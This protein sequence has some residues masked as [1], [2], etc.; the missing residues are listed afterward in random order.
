PQKK[1]VLVKYLG[2]N[3]INHFQGQIHF[4]SSDFS[5]EILNTSRQDGQ[6]YEYSVSRGPE[7][8]VQLIQLKVYEPVSRP[9]IQILSRE[10]ANGSCSVALNCTA[11][12]GDDV[13]YS[14]G[15]QDSGAS[16]PCSANSSFLQ[17]SYAPGNASTACVCTASNPVS[18]RAAAF[19]PSG[20][21]HE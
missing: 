21:S 3:P 13:S 8:E 6:L 11:E 2:G 16:G 5:L 12:R 20:C 1:Q 19:Q 14:W 17:L 10:V 9:S 18:S 4:H 7:E 15:S